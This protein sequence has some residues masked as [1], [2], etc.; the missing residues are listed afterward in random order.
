MDL[1]GLL[2][3]ISSEPVAIEWVKKGSELFGKFYIKDQL[4]DIEV[5]LLDSP[6]DKVYQFKFYRNNETKM[7]NDMKYVIGV[8]PTIKIALDYAVKNLS[9]NI[10]VF[11]SSDK[12]KTRIAMYKLEAARIATEFNY[13]DV[14]K[15]QQLLDMGF[16]TDIIFGIYKSEEILKKSLE[17]L[18]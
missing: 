7:F 4:F 2:L 18:S 17:E 11:A 6:V 12:S 1:K 8:I 9:P 10:L 13:H 3:E 15:S 5:T 14:T 16:S